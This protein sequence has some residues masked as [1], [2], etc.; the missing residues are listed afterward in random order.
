M[1][2]RLLASQAVCKQVNRMVG[3]PVQGLGDTLLILTSPDVLPLLKRLIVEV[4]KEI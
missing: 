1:E 3:F 2:E 4:E